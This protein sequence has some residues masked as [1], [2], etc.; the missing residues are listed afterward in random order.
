MLQLTRWDDDAKL[1]E[2]VKNVPVGGELSGA[3]GE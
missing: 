3:F 2:M 1:A